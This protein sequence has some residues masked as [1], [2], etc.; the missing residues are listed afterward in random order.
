MEQCKRDIAA[1]RTQSGKP[2]E[3]PI[4]N[5]S[6]NI[7]N[8]IKRTEVLLEQV[9]L[10]V[11]TDIERQKKELQNS[12]ND[13]KSKTLGN[14]SNEADISAK[15]QAM[16]KKALVLAK[17]VDSWA[18]GGEELIQSLSASE[19]N[20]AMAEARAIAKY[21]GL[22]VVALGQLYELGK[23]T[24]KRHEFVMPNTVPPNKDESY[25]RYFSNLF[26]FAHNLEEELSTYRKEQQEYRVTLFKH[27]TL[28]YIRALLAS[29]EPVKK[30]NVTSPIKTISINGNTIQSFA[31]KDPVVERLRAYI[32]AVQ[33]IASAD[34]DR[35]QAEAAMV[36]A[37]QELTTDLAA[38]LPLVGDAMDYYN[39]YAGVD[40]A[41]RCLSRFEYGLT[42]VFSAIP[43]LPSGW[44]TQ[45]VKRLGMEDHLSELAL[46]MAQSA[47]WGEEM[48]FGVAKRFDLKPEHFIK[49]QQTGKWAGNLLMTEI[50]VMP[51]LPKGNQWLKDAAQ[52]FGIS[53]S[54]MSAAWNK[55]NRE[56][57]LPG[58]DIDEVAYEAG[59]FLSK[60][61]GKTLHKPAND[62]AIM[63][64][65]LDLALEN[66]VLFR[67]MPKPV[68]E[69]LLQRS[70]K[71]ITANIASLPANS[72]AAQGNPTQVFDMSN[73]VPEHLQE[74]MVE[75]KSLDNVMVFR[76]VNEHATDPIRNSRGT[77]SMHVKGKSADWGPQAAYIPVDQNFSKLGNKN[78]PQLGK[79]AEFNKKV[80]KCI[81]DGICKQTALVLNNGDEVM[82]WKGIGGEIPV[83]KRN[84]TFLKYGSEK[85]LDVQPADT[86]PMMVMAEI[87]PKTGKLEPITADYDLLGIGSKQDVQITKLDDM[88]GAIDDIERKAKE[89]LNLAGERA[90]YEGGD[91]VHH[92][93]ETNNPFT[94]GAFDK[95]PLVTVLDPEKG[96]L[97]IPKCD[98]ACMQKWCDTTG[99]CGGLPLCVENN[100]TMP[101]LVIDPDR[102]LKDFFNDARLRGYT[103]LK[104]NSGWQWGEYNG[105]AG[106]SPLVALEGSGLAQKDWVI[107]Q[108]LMKIGVKQVKRLAWDTSR[109]LD[110]YTQ[111][112]LKAAKQS[113]IKA[114]KMLF[115]CP[116]E[117]N[118]A[119]SL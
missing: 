64:K 110:T 16:R 87:H 66:Q 63:A 86:R 30:C 105:I 80:T 115:S 71:R 15:D 25:S 78:S 49:A 73:M 22:D 43:F 103:T 79:V 93:S 23:N 109:V 113:A 4:V 48:I 107:G 54:T 50:A 59:T 118:K 98:R 10:M 89:R 62:K 34:A 97:T 24:I 45:A 76:Y 26:T 69:E 6:D 29:V 106:W 35:F 114:T 74:F 92:G 88:E 14:P 37:R 100:P 67:N 95:D 32:K 58:V 41:G 7:A 117:T 8:L 101:C 51:G 81:N 82:I 53:E 55:L 70:Q 31:C 1:G 2:V 68:H 96:F 91:L 116:G 60:S 65:N 44:A 20:V 57:T 9:K 104:P 21:F 46:F 39:L 61:A 28:A 17:Q 5:N 77:K 36:L 40:L 94:P 75:A 72:L 47:E 27:V 42:A 19:L 12:S 56:I 13:I 111:L 83:I 102:L 90:G 52:K 3:E 112:Q 99:Q 85:V 11:L 38:G 33:K 119:G 108:Y 84:D 18:T